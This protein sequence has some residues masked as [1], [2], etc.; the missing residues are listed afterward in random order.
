M[1]YLQC[2]PT[3]TTCFKSEKEYLVV[4]GGYLTD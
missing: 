1:S 4:I 3:G 2:H